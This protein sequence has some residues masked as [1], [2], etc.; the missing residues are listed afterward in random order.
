[1]KKLICFLLMLIYVNGVYAQERL[2]VFLDCDDCPEDFIRQRIDFV[3]FVRDRKVADIHV[4]ITRISSGG[5]GSSYELNFLSLDDDLKS[6]VSIRVDAL[7]TQTELEKNEQLLHHINAGLTPYVFDYSTYELKLEMKDRQEAVDEKLITDP[8]NFW[9]F[10]IG[11]E[12]DFAQESNQAEYELEGEIDIER[13][14]EEWR[15]RSEYNIAYEERKVKRQSETLISYLKESEG[16]ASIV[17]SLNNHWSAGIFGQMSSS[18]YN[19]VTFGT[20]WQAAVEYNLFPYQM[21]ATREFTFAYMVGP[22][23]FNYADET[24]YNKNSE[25][26][27]LHSLRIIYD[28]RQPW[29]RIEAELEGANYFHDWRKNRAELEAGIALRVFKGL[30]LRLEM[31]GAII[32]DQLFLPKGDASLEEILLERR[33]LSTDYELGFSVGVAY[34]FGSIYNSIV[35]TR[36]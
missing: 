28:T 18:T 17:K 27:Y 2:N 30:F 32:R 15:I 24:I 5:G 31:E 9:V 33:A 3:N 6:K 22:Q 23:F 20:R 4:F 16:E 11:G 21:S 26:R 34:T 25:Q 10:E 7:P 13:T 12:V 14:T 19:N 35:N 1:M 29:G 8:W 36:L